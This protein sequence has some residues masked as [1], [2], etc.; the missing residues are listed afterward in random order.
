MRPGLLFSPTPTARS[1]IFRVTPP[2][3]SRHT[4]ALFFPASFSA[5]SPFLSASQTP[6]GGDSSSSL[7]R[8]DASGSVI[9][10]DSSS[11]HYT[12]EERDEVCSLRNDAFFED[13]SEP[14]YTDPSMFE[15][16]RSLKSISPSD[17]NIKL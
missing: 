12:E 11:S 17:Q 8:R 7:R 14:I 15:R 2:Q 6:D 1:S 9:S 4:P 3:L 16:S 10:G 13:P 5:P